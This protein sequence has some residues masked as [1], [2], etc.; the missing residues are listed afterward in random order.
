[1]NSIRHKLSDLQVILNSNAVILCIAETKL[2]D[3]FP[4]AQFNLE[5]YHQPPYRLD[6]TSSS[7]GLLVYVKSSLIS[8]PI[9]PG[10]LPGDIQCISI[11]L[12]L[13]KQKW[14]LLSIYRPPYQRLNYFIKYLSNYID[15]LESNYQNIIIMGDFNAES[16]VPEISSFMTCYNLSSLLKTPTCFKSGAGSCIDLILTNKRMSFKGTTSFETG[17][18]DYHHLIYTVLK[19]TFTPLPP[20][21]VTYRSY[22]GFS[23]VDFLND[24][25]VNLRSIQ[26]GDFSSFQNVFTTTLN[27]HAPIKSKALRGNHQPYVSKS[28]RTAIMK[29][30]QLKNVANKTKSIDD[31]N[32][33]KKQRNYVVNLN[34]RSKKS[35]FVKIGT[36]QNNNTKS[37]WKTYKPLF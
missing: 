22:R 35:F 15:S 26:P 34:R 13:R 33:Y 21:K 4:K 32:R 28:L 24:L 10:S 14:L 20:K 27:R 31:I 25:S 12:N 18:S 1:M 37:Y 9:S 3:S 11:E 6:V 2:D 16:N 30:S 29:R 8:R 23:E 19:T 36:T 7:G 5:G 17:V